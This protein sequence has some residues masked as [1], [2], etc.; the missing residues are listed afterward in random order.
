MT[1]VFATRLLPFVSFDVISYAA[2]L[3]PLT[4]WRFAVATLLGILPASF[5]LAHFGDELATGDLHG[6]VLTVLALG[7]ITLLPLAWRALPLRFRTA[8]RHWFG[9][10]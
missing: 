4:L 5:V 10:R 6:A 7:L 2:G 8:T 3:T 1:V 9:S